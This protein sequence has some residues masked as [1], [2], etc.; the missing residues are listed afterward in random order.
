MYNKTANPVHFQKIR[1]TL[2]IIFMRHIQIKWYHWETLEFKLYKFKT[3][4]NYD[5]FTSVS[6]DFS[7]LYPYVHGKKGIFTHCIP[8]TLSSK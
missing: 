8:I 2:Y 4:D 3:Y 5:I 7:V 6:Y 1:Y